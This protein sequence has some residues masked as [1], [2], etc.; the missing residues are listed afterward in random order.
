MKLVEVIGLKKYYPITA[1]FFSKH[2]GDVRAVDGI[3]FHINEGETLGLVGESGCGKTTTGKTLLRLEEPTEGKILYKG[4]D[5][6]TFDRKRLKTLR[7]EI[8]IIFQDPHASLDPRMMVG[9]AIGEA[10]LIHGIKEEGERSRKVEELLRLVGLKEEHALRY[11]HEFSGGQK[12]RI[13]IARA[14]AVNPKL[15]VADEPVS[16]LD[17]SIQAQI[18]NLMMDLKEKL[19]LTYLFI[20]HNLSVIRHISDRVA[21]MY[22]GKI[23]EMANCE[24]IFKNPLH[25]YTE[26]LLSAVPVPNPHE[27]KERILLRGEV[28]SP[29]SPPPGCRFHTRCPK[30]MEICRREEPKIIEIEK[31]HEV[32]CWLC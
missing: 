11:P 16:A 21:V 17:I 15:I 20:A 10:M 7:G 2:I 32:A 22:L 14:L 24:E 18:L 3:S 8:Q 31:G 13:G 12:Q 5:I 1:G 30:V 27:K 26:A 23:V 9:D 25:P 4:E 29:A 6:T 19:G 28:P